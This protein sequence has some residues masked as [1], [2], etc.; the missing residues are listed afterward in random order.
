LQ[1]DRFDVQPGKV[2]HASL[3]HMTFRQLPVARQPVTSHAHDGPQV[4]PSHEPWA[5]QLT[6]QGPAPHATL[7]H[8]LLPVHWMVHEVAPV[9]R[10]PA[11]HEPWRLQRTSQAKP[12]G[13]TT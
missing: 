10:T 1:P 12:G 3:V 5:G 8:E 13:Q 6:L 4:T 11:R 2:L 7:R 9:Q